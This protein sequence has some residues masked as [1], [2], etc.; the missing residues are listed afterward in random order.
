MSHAKKPNFSTLLERVKGKFPSVHA[1]KQVQGKPQPLSLLTLEESLVYRAAKEDED[2]RL[3]PVPGYMKEQADWPDLN[4]KLV[5]EYT[6][7]Q[8]DG[9]NF[10]E[11]FNPEKAV[12]RLIEDTN[13]IGKTIKTEIRQRVATNRGATL[14][15]QE[16]ARTEGDGG[17]ST[18]FLR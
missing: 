8:H 11:Q 5:A 6:K 9:W 16:L 13:K 14:V 17:R 12:A 15:A 3:S 2:F 7:L 4:A 1:S 10:G 18:K